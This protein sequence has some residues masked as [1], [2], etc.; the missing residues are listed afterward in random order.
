MRRVGR[1]APPPDEACLEQL[2]PRAL[3][4]LTPDRAR[5][6]LRDLFGDPELEITYADEAPVITEIGVRQ[7]RASAE[8]ILNRRDQWTA[9]VFPCSTDGGLDDACAAQFID[10]FGARALRRPLQAAD[11]DWLLGVYEAAAYDEQLP[12][13]DAMDVVLAAI[14]QAPDHVYLI[15]R[16]VSDPTLPDGVVALTDHEIANR[17]SYFLWD[18]MPDADLRQAADAGELVTQSGLRTQIERMLASTRTEAKLQLFFSDW[19]HL[20]G[21]DGLTL[22]LEDS[23]KDPEL[24]PE[25]SPALVA[26]MRTELETLVQDVLYG[27]GEADLDRFFTERRAYVNASLANLYGVD[28]PVDDDTWEWVE[29]DPSERAGVLTRAGFLTVYG[30]FKAQAP[31]RRGVYVLEN[32]LCNDLGEPDPDAD[33]T[34]PEGE[35]EASTIREEVDIRTAGSC[36]SCHSLINPFGYLF[37]NYDAVGRWQDNEVV[38]GNPVDASA[39]LLTS[40]FAGEMANAVE[41][42]DALGQSGQARECFARKWARDAFATKAGEL[43]A[44]AQ[45]EVI[46]AFMESGNIHELISSIVLSQSFRHAR[47]GE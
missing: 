17:L 6:T 5:N 11:R 36:Q 37:E 25:F 3:A 20:N 19:L 22:P 12:F 10:E 34:P 29:L 14:L 2:Q 30:H 45:S 41:L 13:A 43:D 42:S 21:S 32:I 15:E 16:G 4:R 8:F 38:S 35:G 27:E 23:T 9:E 40:E 33:D 26:A 1:S 28:G 46:E 47:T 18:S 44:C 24:Y 39:E 7:L 31:I